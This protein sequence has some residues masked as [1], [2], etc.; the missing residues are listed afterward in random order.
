MRHH[1]RPLFLPASE[2]NAPSAPVKKPVQTRTND[3]K[4]KRS[5]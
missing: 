3:D 4:R 2:Y 5:A 1:Y